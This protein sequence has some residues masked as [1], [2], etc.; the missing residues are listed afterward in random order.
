MSSQNL[1]ICQAIEIMK[2]VEHKYMAS[3]VANKTNQRF[4]TYTIAPSIRLAVQPFSQS[5]IQPVGLLACVEITI[6]IKRIFLSTQIELMLFLTLPLLKTTQQY[7][8][9]NYV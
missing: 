2:V 6:K 3:I 8:G 9:L 1:Q 5:A 4:Q 7:L